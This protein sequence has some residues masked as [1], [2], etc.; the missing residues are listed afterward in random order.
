[1]SGR[2][3]RNS[4]KVNLTISLVFHTT[5]VLAIFFLA[6][7]EGML[8][9]KLKEITVTMAPKEKK[10]EPPKEKPP[11]PKIEPA[12]QVEAPKMLATAPPPRVE[13]VAPPPT[14]APP[15]AAPPTVDLPTMDFTDGAK[16]VQ[17]VSDPSVL[18]KGLVEH[19]LRSNWERP[20]DIADDSYVA[21]V[22]LSIDAQGKVVGNR[23]LKGSGDARWDKTVKAA[24]TAT[25]SIGRSP[26][27]GFPGTIRAR[28]D[29]EMFKTEEVIK[30]SSR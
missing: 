25:K 4:S 14:E 9:K 30:L 12:K 17:S 19:A 21:E 27:K 3:K 16:Q 13:N 29:V 22:E 20:E 2:R 6:A 7:R 28:F 10:P 5:L 26:P 18:Y 1:M 8:G 15:M 24:V 11:E 23:W